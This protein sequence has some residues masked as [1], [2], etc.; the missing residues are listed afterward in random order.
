MQPQFCPQCQFSND[1]NTPFCIKCGTTLTTTSPVDNQPPPLIP[2]IPQ[3]PITPVNNNS[4]NQ[5]SANYSPSPNSLPPNPSRP[6]ISKP[7]LIITLI[8]GVLLIASIGIGA[9]LLFF[10]S[11]D[12]R[13]DSDTPANSPSETN[14]K[15]ELS[16][17]SSNLDLENSSTN[18]LDNS[19]SAGPL[20]YTDQIKAT[21]HKIS[22]AQLNTRVIEGVER[23]SGGQ[24]SE[25]D[26]AQFQ[27]I[28]QNAW[29]CQAEYE[30][31]DFKFGIFVLEEYSAM[32]DLLLTNSLANYSKQS[33]RVV[34]PTDFCRLDMHAENR[35]KIKT[36]PYFED[37]LV[38]GDYMIYSIDEPDLDSSYLKQALETKNIAYKALDY[39]Y[40]TRLNL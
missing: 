27:A 36:L 11:T 8:V 3:T 4:I 35:Q 1:P 30:E 15:A 22:K 5:P 40:C 26:K 38:I 17:S 7:F 14:S 10:K 31:V 18:P 16:E 37:F 39:N 12:S 6:T 19:H 23:S 2:P 29:E 34:T 25:A 9:Y 28:V 33:D 21:C 20:V 13:L 32:M 24:V